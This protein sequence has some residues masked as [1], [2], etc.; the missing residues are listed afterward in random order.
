LPMPSFPFDSPRAAQRL[1]WLRG[2]PGHAR[3]T[4]ER[5]SSDAGYRS[6]WRATGGEG[7]RIV[8]DAPPALEP[9]APWL[10][11]RTLLAAGGVR[12]P[13]VLAEDVEQGFV[14]LE[15]LGPHTCLHCL[16]PATA[17]T[18]FAAAIEQLLRVQAITPPP[19]MA[20]Y[21]RAFLLRELGLFEQWFLRRHL[22]IELAAAQ[23]RQLSACW[24]CLLASALAQPQVLVHRDFMPRNL[25]PHGDTVAVIDFQ[26]ALRGPIAYDA[27]SLFKDAFISWPEADVQRWLAY[28]HRRARAAG[29]PVPEWAQFV[30]DVELIGVQRHLKILGVFARLHYRDNKPQYLRDAA[31]FVAYLEAALPRWPQLAALAELIA[32]RVRPA[33]SA[34]AGA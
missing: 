12:V 23:A 18:L 3:F 11:V 13:E 28:Y 22:G 25:I 30:R 26:D 20:C 31:R 10:R 29:L 6:Y 16:T 7:S 8:M 4:L 33:L 19:D 5:A 17:D 2:L 14:L 15:D 1:A 27:A 9:V 34:A 32:R 24:D 21:D